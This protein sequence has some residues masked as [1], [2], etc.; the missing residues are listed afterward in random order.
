MADGGVA[1]QSPRNATVAALIVLYILTSLAV[2]VYFRRT[3]SD[4]GVWSSLVAP[5]LSSVLM[6]MVM[7]MVVRNF[8]V[9]TGGTGATLWLLLGSVPVAF[10]IGWARASRLPRSAAAELV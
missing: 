7:A 3:T 6:I 10:A 1:A 2:I 9:L 4:A 5:A 8:D